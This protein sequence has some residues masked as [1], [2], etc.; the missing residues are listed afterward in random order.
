MVTVFSTTAIF[1]AMGRSE[2]IKASAKLLLRRLWRLRLRL[3]W[4]RLLLAEVTSTFNVVKAA[5]KLIVP[6]N[7]DLYY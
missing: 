2:V 7:L 5:A 3:M 4:L 6:L 1:D